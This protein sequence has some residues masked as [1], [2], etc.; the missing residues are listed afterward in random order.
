MENMFEQAT[1]NKLRF[2]S[3]KG[4]L[5]VEQV[6]DAPLTSRNGFSL[7][8]IAKQAKR[9]LDALSEES[10][11]EQV[12]PLKSVAVLKLEVVK[13]IISVK[14]AEKEVASKRAER[15]ELRRQLTEALAEKQSDAI[16]NMSPE[17]IQK[18]LK[19][20]ED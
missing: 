10:F 8:D 4:P 14:L 7:D 13:H 5:T 15:A 6:W 17:E 2:E 19:E 9:E 11:V 12:S 1:R 16:K 18:R 3:A 20:L